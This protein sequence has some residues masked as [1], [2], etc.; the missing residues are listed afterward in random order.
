MVPRNAQELEAER[1]RVEELGLEVLSLSN[2]RVDVLGGGGGT[3][4]VC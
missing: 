1:R 2:A 3:N 4:Q